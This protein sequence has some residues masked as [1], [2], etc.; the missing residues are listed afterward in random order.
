MAARLGALGHDHVGSGR[1]RLPRPGH[2][3]HLADQPDPGLPDQRAKRGGIAERQEH[4]RGPVGQGQPDGLLAGRPGDDPDPPRLIRGAGHRAQLALQ[5]A[6]IG[7]AA[8]HQAKAAGLGDRRGQR[9]AGHP[10]H[11]RQH[12]RMIDVEEVGESRP[13]CHPPS[14]PYG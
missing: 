7:V 10:S 3:L 9:P 8:A 6:R 13:D 5:P 4:G 2:V 11:W 14:V 12:E 1:D